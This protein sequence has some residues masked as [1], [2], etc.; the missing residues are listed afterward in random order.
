MLKSIGSHKTV[1]KGQ[2][3]MSNLFC[4]GLLF[5][6][7]NEDSGTTATLAGQCRGRDH[8]GVKLVHVHDGHRLLGGWLA[9]LELK[10]AV[11]REGWVRGE[12]LWVF[13][14]RTLRERG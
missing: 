13:I 5:V 2:L 8:Q 6:W 14:G 10:R 12:G 4:G 3:R 11:G 1:K 7:H 9:A